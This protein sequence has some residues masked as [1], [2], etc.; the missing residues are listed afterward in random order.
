M[1]EDTN[2]NL[3]SKPSTRGIKPWIPLILALIYIVSPIDLV[4]DF[5]PVVGWLED[6]LF[7]VVGGLNG[8]QNGILETNSSLRGLIKFLKW[9]IL[10]VG[11]IAVLIVVLLAVLVFKVA[12]NK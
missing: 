5:I 12:T 8:I 7:M 1:N 6:A 3:P 4:P 10:I 2:E 9:G 11:G